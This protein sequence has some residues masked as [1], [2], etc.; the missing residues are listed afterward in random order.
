MCCGELAGL[1]R[2]LVSQN[3]FVDMSSVHSEFRASDILQTAARAIAAVWTIWEHYLERRKRLSELTELCAMDD[4]ALKDIGIS[5]LGIQAAIRSGAD[6][7]SA[8]E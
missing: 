7:R 3:R 4:V 8:R 5:R 1:R 6:L 2:L